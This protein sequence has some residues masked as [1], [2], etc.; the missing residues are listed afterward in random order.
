MPSPQQDELKQARCP[1]TCAVAGGDYARQGEPDPGAQGCRHAH[2]RNVQ[3]HGPGDGT[4]TGHERH[5]ATQS[6]D[7]G[8]GNQKNKEGRRGHP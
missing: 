1:N 2:R 4:K 8:R 6:K 7:G 3:R 5:T